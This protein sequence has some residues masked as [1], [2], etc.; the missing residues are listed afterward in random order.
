M[1]SDALDTASPPEPM[2]SSSAGRMAE[3]FADY[4]TKD[5]VTFL[6]NWDPQT[7]LTSTSIANEHTQK[8]GPHMGTC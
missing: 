5:L 3:Y 8:A 7:T 4:S 6:G 1:A 2:K